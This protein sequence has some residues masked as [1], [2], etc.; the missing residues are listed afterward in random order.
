[1]NQS[2]LTHQGFQRVAVAVMKPFKPSFIKYCLGVHLGFTIRTQDGHGW[3]EKPLD[4][5]N[6]KLLIK[7]E[8]L[9]ANIAD[10]CFHGK[11]PGWELKNICHSDIFSKI[12]KKISVDLE[13]HI[14]G[15]GGVQNYSYLSYEL[16]DKV[17]VRVGRKFLVLEDKVTLNIWK[18]FS[19]QTC[20]YHD[21][22]VWNKTFKLANI[23]TSKYET[24]H[25][26]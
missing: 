21:Y 4:V 5:I 22:K 6:R 19:W 11:F 1:M 8:S 2:L 25:Y 16:F 18:I 3:V 12:E 7:Q 14:G 13:F 17:L 15:G 24:K 23:M 10:R 20:K 26:A 9:K